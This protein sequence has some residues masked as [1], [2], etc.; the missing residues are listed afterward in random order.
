[1]LNLKIEQVAQVFWY[2]EVLHGGRKEGVA[3]CASCDRFGHETGA[4]CECGLTEIAGMLFGCM[5]SLWVPALVPASQVVMPPSERG[6]TC[7]ENR[8]GCHKSWR[9]IVC[10]FRG[11]VGH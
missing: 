2:L 3:L 6:H 4:V 7:R 10:I 8:H 1:M 9:G 11:D 5:V